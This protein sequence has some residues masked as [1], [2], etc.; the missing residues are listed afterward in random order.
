MKTATFKM[1]NKV[2]V[3]GISIH[4]VMKTATYGDFRKTNV[5]GDFNP[6]SHEDCNTIKIIRFLKKIYFNPCS[7]EDCNSNPSRQ[8]T[9]DTNFNPCSHEDCNAKAALDAYNNMISIHAV[10]KTATILITTTSGTTR[11]SIH[12][13]MKT[14]TRCAW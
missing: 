1:T 14:A 7:H 9:D 5:S 13:V 3:K 4:A 8:S 6:C 12:A 10:M 2:T 11:I